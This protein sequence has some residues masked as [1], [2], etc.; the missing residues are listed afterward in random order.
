MT[1]PKPQPARPAVPA[2]LAESP[3]AVLHRVWRQVHPD[4]RARFF[5]E[6]LTPAERRLVATGLW[7]DDEEA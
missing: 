1:R 2:P 4:D 3:L 7:P 6:M 5:L